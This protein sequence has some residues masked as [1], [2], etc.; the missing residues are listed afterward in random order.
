MK[1]WGTPLIGTKRQVSENQELSIGDL[2]AIKMD[3][4]DIWD[5]S[6]AYLYPER[7]IEKIQDEF[8]VEGSFEP[9]FIKITFDNPHTGLPPYYLQYYEVHVEVHAIVLHASPLVIS[10]S[11]GL[12]ILALIILAIIIVVAVWT[13]YLIEKLGAGGAIMV[14][15]LVAVIVIVIFMVVSGRGRAKS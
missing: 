8:L 10:V 6:D 3:K 15:A 14:L 13:Y 2:I 11:T 5:E 12:I 9:K 7:L 1:T 4:G